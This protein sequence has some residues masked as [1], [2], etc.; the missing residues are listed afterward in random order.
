MGSK[1][2]FYASYGEG[3]RLGVFVRTI[4][5]LDRN[6][7][8]TAFG[9]FLEQNQLTSDQI[10]F[11]DQIVDHLAQNGVLDPELLFAPPFTNTHHEGVSGVFPIRADKVIGIVRQ[12]NENA[13]VA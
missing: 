5:D 2:D 3:K 13:V 12:V 6:A 11:V 7:A 8:K 4:V 1:E 10:R 9:G